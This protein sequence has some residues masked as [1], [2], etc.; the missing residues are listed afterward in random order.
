MSDNAVHDAERAAYL[1]AR[2]A[3]KEWDYAES[4][5]P[6]TYD[7]IVDVGVATV[8]VHTFGRVSR[9]H[10]AAPFDPAALRDRLAQQLQARRE[11]RR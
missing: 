9:D 6:M 10:A 2:A 7:D 4:D 1:Q 5:D 3:L 11:A 8:F